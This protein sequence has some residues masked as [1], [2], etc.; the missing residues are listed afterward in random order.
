LK[1][2]NTNIFNKYKQKKSY[3]TFQGKTKYTL[4]LPGKSREIYRETP[5]F[6]LLRSHRENYLIPGISRDFPAGVR[7]KISGIYQ[8]FT[9]ISQ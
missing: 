4:F 2:Q 7:G 6:Q 3:V 8:L 1:I 9:G 5:G